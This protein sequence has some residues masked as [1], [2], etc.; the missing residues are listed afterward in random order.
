[1][2]NNRVTAYDETTGKGLIRHVLIRKG[3]YSGEIMVCLVI[4]KS[5]KRKGSENHFLPLQENLITALTRIKG[6]A[7]ISVSSQTEKTN[8]IMGKEI[9][10]IWGQDFI[11]DKI[12]VRNVEE[13]FTLQGD[14][15]TFAISP[16]SFYQVNPVQTEK[17]YSLA[18]SYAGL[19]GKKRCGIF[20]VA[21]EQYPCFW[22][23]VPG[24]YMG[25]RW[26][27]RQLKMQRKMHDK[28]ALGMLHFMWEGQRKCF[29]KSMKRKRS[30]PM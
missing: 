20:I 10:T 30:M 28:M 24:R 15:I 1:M 7:S 8:V 23:D 2:K 25:L 6:M 9:Y 29:P 27:L 18:L 3:F 22:Q 13:G 12:F 17:L 16:R 26:F 5:C 14:G 19:S 11:H 4:N 21:L